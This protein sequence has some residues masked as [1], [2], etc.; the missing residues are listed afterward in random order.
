[1][2]EEPKKPT[3]APDGQG[4]TNPDKGNLGVALG[5]ERERRKHLE[6]EHNQLAEQYKAMQTELDALKA[7]APAQP[8]S[9]QVP[10]D[11]S[12]FQGVMLDD[13][14]LMGAANLNQKLNPALNT[15]YERTAGVNE[16]V[17]A[18]QEELEKAKAAQRQLQQ[19]A[20]QTVQ[21]RVKSQ[22]EMFSDN[23]E[24]GEGLGTFAQ[25]AEVLYRNAFDTDDKPTVEEAAAQANSV[26]SALRA[27]QQHV[28]LGLD[29]LAA[30]ALAETNEAFAP[31]PTQGGGSPEERHLNGTPAYKPDPEKS[32]AD[33]YRDAV[34]RNKAFF[35]RANKLSQG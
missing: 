17:S 9:P 4:D 14:D 21:E 11:P 27:K 7:K 20:S 13:D 10:N 16:Q 3:P 26:V 18:L 2:A 32:G 25:L 23:A 22:Y 31:P 6:N 29:D 35:A 24:I 19:F 30:K 8:Q 5:K 34:A 28:E 1:M 12:T 33:K 15:L